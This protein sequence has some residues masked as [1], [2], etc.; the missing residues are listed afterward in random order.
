MDYDNYE[1][2]NQ[3]EIMKI[4]RFGLQKKEKEFESFFFFFIVD[5]QEFESLEK[6]NLVL[7]VLVWTQNRAS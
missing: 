5:K 3:P 2:G 6:H 7:L 4:F 1:R